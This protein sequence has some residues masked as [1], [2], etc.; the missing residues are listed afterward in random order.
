VNQGS[1]LEGLPGC[2]RCDSDAANR[3]NSA[4]STGNN[5]SAFCSST[6][7]GSGSLFGLDMR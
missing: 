4:Y 5:S 1:R 2:N 3:R 7:G 6:A